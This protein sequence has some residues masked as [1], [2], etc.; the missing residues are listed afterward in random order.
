MN[1]KPAPKSGEVPLFLAIL[2]LEG[3]VQAVLWIIE[4]GEINILTKSDV[5]DYSNENDC[6]IKTDEA[7]QELGPE[8]EEVQEVIFVFEP[9]WI[10]ATDLKADK[11]PLVKKVTQDLS[12]KPLGFV[13]STEALAQHFMVSEPDQALILLYFAQNNLNVSLFEHNKLTAEVNLGQC[14]KV[15]D[16]LIEGL[17]QLKNKLSDPAKVFPNKV[18]LASLYL[19]EDKIQAKQQSL[20]T[21]HFDKKYFSQTPMV[22]VF[23]Q[24][25]LFKIAV[26]EAGKVVAGSKQIPL[27]INNKVKAMASPSPESHSATEEKAI[28]AE[29][30]SFGVPIK[31]KY[32]MGTPSQPLKSSEFELV[33]EAAEEEDFFEPSKFAKLSKFSKPTAFGNLKRIMILGVFTG[34]VIFSLLAF[35]WLKFFSIVMVTITPQS[36][37]I[38]KD[39][40][41]ILD[42]DVAESNPAEL[43]L[44][45]KLVTKEY[46]QKGLDV[47]SGEKTIGEPAKGKITIFNKTTEVKTFEKDTQITSNNLVFTLDESVKVA[48]SS[49]VTNTSGD[50][51][52]KEY[53]KAEVAVTAAEI[54]SESNLNKDTAFKIADY[55]ENTYS[56]VALDNF[57]GGESSDVQVVTKQDRANLLE[58]VQAEIK[59]QAKADFEEQSSNGTYYILTNDLTVDKAEF[60]AEVDDEADTLNLNLSAT[61]TAVEYSKDDLKPLAQ[62]YLSS[63]VPG[64]FKLADKDP[65]ILSSPKDSDSDQV[66]LEANLSSEAVAILDL[67]AIKARL[68]GLAVGELGQLKDEFLIKNLSYQINPSLAKKLVNQIPS[69]AKRLSVTIKD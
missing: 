17:A 50:G 45:A 38:N 35:L 32:I 7:L 46:T 57:T 18:Y 63:L 14:G 60:D 49:V 66:I 53:G 37:M 61:V 28:D 3:S 20:I 40:E 11:K 59:K 47:T 42:P 29:M 6:L 9:D 34:L 67:E 12:L 54:G 8:S 24:K 2:L 30:S 69:S 16:D 27:K 23:A 52:T 62:E 19:P 1:K 22:E 21:T 31:N 58:S 5:K 25:K 56:A 36:Q 15:E 33:K 65:E 44:K 13:V 41:I 39:L 68:L 10:A 55:D 4:D 48:S 51:E 26:E 43:I 64:G